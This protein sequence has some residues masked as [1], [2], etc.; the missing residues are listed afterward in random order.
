MSIESVLSNDQVIVQL[1]QLM[2]KEGKDPLTRGMEC[3]VDRSFIGNILNSN[4]SVLSQ[5]IA[6]FPFV[7][8]AQRSPSNFK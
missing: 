6:K 4:I 1:E 7:N 2:A 8:R 3:F 5:V